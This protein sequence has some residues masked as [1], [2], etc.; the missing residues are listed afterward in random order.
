MADNRER[1]VILRTDRKIRETYVE[2]NAKSL[3]KDQMRGIYLLRGE[4]SENGE[5]V[6]PP[7]GW[8]MSAQSP[9]RAG[10]SRMRTKR[11]RCALS[12]HGYGYGHGHGSSTV[13]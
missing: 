8:H 5:A 2:V 9:P 1:R 10:P 11:V 6:E 12:G 4:V 3:T 13:L 7:C